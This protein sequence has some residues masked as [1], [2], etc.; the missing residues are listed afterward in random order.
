MRVKFS[1]EA[2]FEELLDQRCQHAI[3]SKQR[4]P[5]LQLLLSLLLEL[6]K[7]ERVALG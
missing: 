1:L 6:V 7:V 5:L 3:C 4:G 2:L